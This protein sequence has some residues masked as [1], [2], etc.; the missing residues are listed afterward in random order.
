L[1]QERFCVAED[2]EKVTSLSTLDLLL[3]V[4]MVS[5]N[6]N[7]PNYEEALAALH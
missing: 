7:E 3:L 2:I 4:I 1:A 6:A 5:E